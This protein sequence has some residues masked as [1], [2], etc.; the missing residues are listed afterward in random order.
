MAGWLEGG[1]R[2]GRLQLRIQPSKFLFETILFPDADYS[3]FFH[4]RTSIGIGIAGFFFA[5]LGSFLLY[6][7]VVMLRR[8]RRPHAA[9]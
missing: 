6:Q 7:L 5:V 2:A 9:E 3:L 1:G 8:R 4:L